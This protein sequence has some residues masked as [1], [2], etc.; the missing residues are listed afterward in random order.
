VQFSSPGGARTCGPNDLLPLREVEQ[1]VHGPV[2]ALEVQHRDGLRP[3][4]RDPGGRRTERP[5]LVA[6]IRDLWEK[7]ND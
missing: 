6:P 7:L 4:S 5:L 3:G 1:E 2:E